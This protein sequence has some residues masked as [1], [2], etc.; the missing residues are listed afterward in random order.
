MGNKP[1]AFFVALVKQMCYTCHGGAEVRKLIFTNPLYR[2]KHIVMIAGKIF[3][4]KT[5]RDASR[6][7]NKVTRKYPGK[8]PTIT[9][10]P[11]EDA[12]I[13]WLH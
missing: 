5:G 8:T 12:L 9:Y 13:L 3:T 1:S 2:G 10:V 7:F 6:I 4:A 11:K